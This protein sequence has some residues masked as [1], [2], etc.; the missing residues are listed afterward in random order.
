M[1]QRDDL[2]FLLCARP[3]VIAMAILRLGKH[4]VLEK[5]IISPG[6]SIVRKICQISPI[7]MD[8]SVSVR[9]CVCA[10]ACVCVFVCV[11]VSVY[12]C[13]LRSFT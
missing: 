1:A 6:N 7:A 8:L 10:C 4:Y 2:L 3:V 13:M 9:V 11:C 5:I 12:V